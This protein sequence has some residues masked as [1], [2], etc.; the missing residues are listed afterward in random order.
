MANFIKSKDIKVFPAGFRNDALDTSKLTTEENL[1]G[2]TIL[3]SD[4]TIGNRWITNP[5]NENE[6]IIYIDGYKF[7]FSKDVVP[8][9]STWAAIKLRKISVGNNTTNVLKPIESTDATATALD[10]N[11]EDGNFLGLGFYTEEPSGD[12]V[13]KVKNYSTLV[14]NSSEIKNGKTNVSIDKS[15]NTEEA[16]VTNATIKNIVLNGNINNL[17]LDASAG[18]L[19]KDEENVTELNIIKNKNLKIENNKATLGDIVLDKDN[20][21]DVK[22]NDYFNLP[23]NSEANKLLKSDGKTN[24]WISY[25]EEAAATNT[26]V[27]RKG[28]DI[29]TSTLNDIEIFQDDSE[30]EE[31]TLKLRYIFTKNDVSVK[32]GLGIKWPATLTVSGDGSIQT[33]IDNEPDTGNVI[34]IGAGTLIKQDADKKFVQIGNTEKGIEKAITLP[35]IG[36]TGGV[37]YDAGNNTATWKAT[38]A[39]G[40]ALGGDNKYKIVMTDDTGCIRGL[41]PT[42]HASSASTYGLATDDKHGNKYGHV[43]IQTGD[44]KN[45]AYKEGIVAS[46]EHEHS[47]YATAWT[48]PFKNPFTLGNNEE[49][50][51]NWGDSINIP[52][53]TV[54]ERGIIEGADSKDVTITLPTAYNKVK[55]TEKNNSQIYLTGITTASAAGDYELETNSNVYIGSDNNLYA[56]QLYLTS[57]KRLKENEKIYK[58]NKSVLDLPIYK[59]DYINGSKNQIGCMAQDLKEICPEIVEEDEEGYLHIQESKIVYLLIEEIRKLKEEINNLKK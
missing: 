3:S 26:I 25:S 51:L 33:D 29:K 23:K 38:T 21:G 36:A 37:L 50:T 17:T 35:L 55:V 48:N 9:G 1:T 14:L 45:S 5:L 34:S 40:H 57:D 2:L 43:K 24:S 8:E 53:F 16:T 56:P 11:V 30:A 13:Y 7:V 32:S 4:K 47:Q 41:A 12:D 58:C 6:Y 46:I 18:I 44:L 19:I 27:K 59:Y 52:K 22:I 49:T 31:P 15:F 28:N 42:D 20:A 39:N 54:N 10:E